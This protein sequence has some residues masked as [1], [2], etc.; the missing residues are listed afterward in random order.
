MI[1]AAIAPVVT[2]GDPIGAVIIGTPSQQ[3]TVGDLEETL[4]V[5]AAGY[6]GRQV[7]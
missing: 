4:V 7:E 3:R 5:T 2:D 6:I 1:S